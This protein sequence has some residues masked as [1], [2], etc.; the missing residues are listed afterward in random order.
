M[1]DLPEEP[2]R[3]LDRDQV[4]TRWSEEL[5][6]FAEKTVLRWVQRVKELQFEVRETGVHVRMQTHDDRGCY[7]FAF[8]IFPG[9]APAG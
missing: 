8:D 1:Q 3:D 4:R 6:P 9:R 2:L 7:R 5:Y